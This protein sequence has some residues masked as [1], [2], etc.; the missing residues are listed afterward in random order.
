VLRLIKNIIDVGNRYQDEHRR[1]LPVGMCGEMSGDI[2][3]TVLLLG[4][5]LKEF[6][7]SSAMIPEIKNVIRSVDMPTARKIADEAMR[8]A[9]S[10][11]TQ[12]YLRDVSERL[13]AK[14][15]QKPAKRA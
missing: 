9:D 12:R 4:M 3:Y 7:V 2:A 1:G 6:S 11:E 8:F 13:A 14:P 15:P 10:D 5:G